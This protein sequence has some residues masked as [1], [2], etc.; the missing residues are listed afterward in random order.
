MADRS[1]DLLQGI[2]SPHARKNTQEIDVSFQA[3]LIT[4]IKKNAHMTL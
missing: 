1:Y 3:K 4:P 2:T